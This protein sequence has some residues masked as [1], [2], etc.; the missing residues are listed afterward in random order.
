MDKGLYAKIHTSKGV[1]LGKLE[2]EKTPMTVAN[3]VGLAEGKIEN[4]AKEKGE[5]YFDGLKFHRVIDNFMV[6]GG[7]P[8][9]TGAGGPGYN[10]P[11]EFHPELNHNEPGAFSMAN[12]GPGTN[13]S[14]FFIT[15]VPTTWLDNKH[16]VFGKVVEGQDVVNAIAQ[17]DLMEKVE[18]IRV[19]EDA[20]AFEADAVF[21]AALNGLEDKAKAEAAKEEEKMADLIAGF[22]STESGLKYKITKSVSGASPEKGKDVSVHYK[23]SLINGQVFDESYSRKQPITFKLGVG[24]VIPGW[25]EGIALL[26]EGEEAR[27]IIPPQLAYGAAG[28]GGV[29]PPNAWLIFDVSLVKAG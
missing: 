26:K 12:A 23:G 25:D 18:I 19:G 9:G 29:I 7:D 5:A 20:E 14:Q 15:H 22:D 21:T 16:S 1:I 24:Q 13:G 4:S 8:N 17:D 10:F 27:F 6:Q 3:F 2:F 11:D 28:A